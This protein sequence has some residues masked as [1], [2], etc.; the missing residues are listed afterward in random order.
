MEA[1]DT[2]KMGLVAWSDLAAVRRT[3]EWVALDVKRIESSQYTGTN[4]IRLLT[5]IGQHA[6]LSTELNASI[7]QLHIIMQQFDGASLETRTAL[8]EQARTV[9]DD[10]VPMGELGARRHDM[11]RKAKLS[12]PEGRD[13]RRRSKTEDASQSE[14]STQTESLDGD[15][16]ATE[17]T[18]EDK[19]GSEDADVAATEDVNVELEVPASED[20][21][22]EPVAPRSLVEE[23]GLP[24]TSPPKRSP[25]PPRR[26]EWGHPEGTGASVRVL[27]ATEDVVQRLTN[28]GMTT[29]G[30]LL[31]CPPSG[32]VCFRQTRLEVP[33]T[34]NEVDVADVAASLEYTPVQL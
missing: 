13:R 7:D 12:K 32:H 19:L 34:D 18:G 6:G 29:V 17:E 11:Q 21:E 5:K 24:A 22:T 20:A 25:R 33:D 4:V 15:N 27:G 8:I 16:N 26:F 31:Q 1:V 23:F 2:P 3:I 14:E 10:L 30:D 9:L 28:L